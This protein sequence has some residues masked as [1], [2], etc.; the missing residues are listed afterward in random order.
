MARAD[1]C[2]CVNCGEEFFGLGGML[3]CSGC[4]ATRAEAVT[5]TRDRLSNSGI[6]LARICSAGIGGT[7]N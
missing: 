1:F 5:V 6:L 7:T 4:Q 2:D 3:R